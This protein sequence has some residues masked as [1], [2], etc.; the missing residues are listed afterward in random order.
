[1]SPEKKKQLTHDVLSL[2]LALVA[3]LMMTK[4]WP[5][6]LL[7]ILGLFGYDGREVQALQGAVPVPAG[8][9]DGKAVLSC[10]VSDSLGETS[11]MNINKYGKGPAGCTVGPLS[12]WRKRRCRNFAAIGNPRFKFP[13]V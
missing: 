6:L 10:V 12:F 13:T 1:M 4:L 8:R 5:I 2:I 11:R 9:W 3:L 7:V